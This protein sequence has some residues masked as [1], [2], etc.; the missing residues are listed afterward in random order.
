MRWID[1]ILYVECLKSTRNFQL[2]TEKERFI[3]IMSNENHQILEKLSNF[4]VKSLE[5]REQ[6]IGEN[7]SG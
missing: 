4:I 5:S 6:F 2:L 7:I 3:F 1:L